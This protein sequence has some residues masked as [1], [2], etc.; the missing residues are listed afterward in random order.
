M[1]EEKDV[2][3]GVTFPRG[4]VAAGVKAGI[5]KSGN[6][7]VAVIYT[8]RDW[9]SSRDSRKCRVRKCMYW[10]DWN[11]EFQERAR[12]SSRSIRLQRR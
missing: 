1:F 5:K 9:N 8:D 7:D 2:K 12:N 3:A 4:F 6:L 10:R 11:D